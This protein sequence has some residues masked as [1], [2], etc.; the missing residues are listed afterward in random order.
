MCMEYEWS[1]ISIANLGE[2]AQQLFIEKWK[3]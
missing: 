3:L 2:E 1:V